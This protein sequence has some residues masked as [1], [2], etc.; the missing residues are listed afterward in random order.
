[1]LKK[2]IIPPYTLYF[3][4]LHRK[5]YALYQATE[6][7]QYNQDFVA[8]LFLVKIRLKIRVRLFF[9][10]GGTSGMVSRKKFAR[11]EKKFVVSV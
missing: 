10:N 11:F 9:R 5:V 1:M 7:V 6:V 3:G 8:Q 4:I 2:S